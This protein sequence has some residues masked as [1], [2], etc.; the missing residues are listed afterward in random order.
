MLNFSLKQISYCIVTAAFLIVMHTKNILVKYYIFAICIYL[1]FSAVSYAENLTFG[2]PALSIDKETLRN[3]LQILISEDHSVSLVAVFLLVKTGSARETDYWGSGISHLLEHMMFKDTTNKTAREIEQQIK[4]AGGFYNGYTSFDSTGYIICLRA[5]NFD[6]AI[7]IL[8]D[9]VQNPLFREEEFNKEKA[10][11]Q[12]EMKM[13]LDDPDK[14]LSRVFLQ[15]LYTRHPYRF[16]I[17]G[18]ED[19][20]EKITLNDLENYYK[21]KYQPNNMIIA[22]AGDIDSESALKKISQEFGS[23]SQSLYVQDKF[24]IEP[25]Q[26]VQRTNVLNYNLAQ[27][28]LI[29]GFHSVSIT[30]NDLFA[31]DVLAIILGE[32]KS[33]LLYQN[34]YK[35]GLVRSISCFNFTPR[36]PGSF[37][38]TCVVNTDINEE[39]VKQAIWEQINRAKKGNISQTQLSRAKMQLFKDYVDRLEDLSGQARDLALSY[40]LTGDYDFSR[41]YLNKINQVSIADLKRVAKKYLNVDNSTTVVLKRKTE[42]EKVNVS[43]NQKEH[44]IDKAATKINLDNGIRVILKEKEKLPMVSLCLAIEGGLR[45]EDEKTN[46]RS[47]LFSLML[48]KGTKKYSQAKLAELAESYGMRINNF[49]GHNSFGVTI[50]AL[51]CDLELA[52][53]IL[54]E[55]VTNPI[56]PADEF[57]LAKKTLLAEIESIDDDIFSYTSSVLKRVLYQKYPYRF[58][59]IG[60]LKSVSNFT[61]GDLHDFYNNYLC[62]KNMVISAVGDFDTAEIVLKLKRKFGHLPAKSQPPLESI[63]EPQI[64]NKRYIFNLREDKQQAVILYGFHTVALP[65]KLRYA[66]E[67]ISSI[68]DSTGG[69]LYE[70]IRMQ[71]GMSYTLGGQNIFGPEQGYYLLYIATQ[72][73]LLNMVIEIVDWEIENLTVEQITDQEINIAKNYLIGMHWQ[74]LQSCRALSLDFA[75]NELY[76]IGFNDYLEYENKINSVTRSDIKEALDYLKLAKAAVVVTAPVKQ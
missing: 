72:P 5:E 54:S 63:S 9:Q 65:D 67:L 53:D 55:I 6:T 24:Y 70:K 4:N 59:P 11:I 35:A 27:P 26:L 47:N 48:T 32:G 76:G 56:F 17:I 15:D 29:I 31:L 52:I 2:T 16:P 20:F 25:E 34:V 66:L 10:V 13:C 36:D 51:S 49:S 75:L 74:G 60:S 45:S 1:T 39:K 73:Q 44:I 42:D 3:S 43:D 61:V 18:C 19:I 50:D 8:A 33:S 12:S 68:L 23:F 57:K 7:E 40:Y 64:Q 22:V 38:I 21:K 37:G 30:D 46:G 58:L 14:Y 71:A 28:H 69:R 41:K 62:T